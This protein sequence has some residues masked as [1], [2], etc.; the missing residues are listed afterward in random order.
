MA[1]KDAWCSFLMDLLPPTLSRFLFSIFAT[2]SNRQIFWSQNA[3]RI[4][5]LITQRR[6]MRLLSKERKR[7][8]ANSGAIGTV[9]LSAAFSEGMRC[10]R[11]GQVCSNQSFNPRPRFALC[12]RHS[13]FHTQVLSRLCTSRPISRLHTSTRVRPGIH[14]QVFIHTRTYIHTY[15]RTHDYVIPCTVSNS[16]HR[17]SDART[18]AHC[19]HQVVLCNFSLDSSSLSLPRLSCNSSVPSPSRLFFVTTTRFVGIRFIHIHA[20]RYDKCDYVIS[21]DRL[22]AESLCWH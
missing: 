6:E 12:W 18:R 9:S 5:H 8:C 17:W 19:P 20:F 22:R 15:T 21:R 2:F 14:T 4:T 7:Y 3:Q 16:R 10:P 11:F 13:L 1:S